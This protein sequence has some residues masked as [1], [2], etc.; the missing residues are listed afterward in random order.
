MRSPY[1]PVGII[2]NVPLDPVEGEPAALNGGHV[3]VLQV[4][5]PVGVLDDGAGVAGE[6]VLH[7]ASVLRG[8][9]S[10]GGGGGRS[11]GV[12]PHRVGRLGAVGMGLRVVV[13]A[14][15]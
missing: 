9:G 3:V 4:H 15:G 7:F 8:G 11:L 6:E 2:V 12:L 1:A 13:S 10:G 14:G 5:D